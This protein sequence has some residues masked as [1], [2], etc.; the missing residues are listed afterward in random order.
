MTNG[1]DA[2]TVLTNRAGCLSRAGIEFVGRYYKYSDTCLKRYE[3]EALSRAGIWI[4]SIWEL[5]LPTQARYFNRASGE[6]AGQHS[7]GL[8]QDA[9]QPAGTAIYYTVDYDADPADLMQIEEYFHGIREARH[10]YV[11]GVYG[12]GLVCQHIR[13]A[14]LAEKS[15]LAAPL[16]WRGSQ[17][18]D[19]DIRQIAVERPL[20]GVMVDL[21]ESRGDG[22]GWRID[23]S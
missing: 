10:D 21:D 8:A 3:A 2:N 7:A 9:G 17:Y 18:S 16:G 4:V 23:T 19:W 6:A 11:I 22:G 20:C 1:I 15:W 14:G 5:G 13:A 12:S